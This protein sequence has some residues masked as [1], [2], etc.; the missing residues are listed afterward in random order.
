MPIL[1]KT[2][3][4]LPLDWEAHNNLGYTLQALGQSSVAE[5][6]CRRALE[7]KPDYP[8]AH[9]NLGNALKDLGRLEEAERS[10]RRALELKRDYAVVHSNLGNLLKDLG[11]LEEAERSYR[12]ALELKPDYAVAHSNLIFTLD[13][14]EHC[15]TRMQQEE[16][17]RWY[18]QH[19]RRYAQAIRPHENVPGPERKLR[20]G[21]VSADFCRRSPYYA[22]GSIICGHDHSAFEVVCYSEGLREDEATARLRR[23]AQVWRS[24]VGVS[25]EALAEQI[26][27]DRID[28]LVD[29]SAHM[30]GSRLLVFARKPAPVQVTAWGYANGTGLQTMDYFFADS[31]AVPSEERIHY[32]EEVTDLP[33]IICYEPPEYLPAVSPLPALSGKPFTF[34]CINR[35]EKITGSV[36]ALWCR[37]LAALPEARLVIKGWGLYDQGLRGNLL[38]RFKNAD[39]DA[40]RVRLLGHSPHAEHLK[41]YHE[42]DLV[43][44]SY[45]HG[46]GIS[47]L[48]ALWMGVPVV[49]LKGSTVTSRVS[50]SILTA[51]KLQDWIAGSDEEYGRIALEA[52]RDLPRLGGV[53]QGLR[54]R[55]GASVVG[56]V[57]RYTRAVEATYRTVWRRWCA[58]ETAAHFDVGADDEIPQNKTDRIG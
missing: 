44:D 48:E 20:I 24:S 11:R 5:A 6:C 2:V 37:I 21:Y 15:D 35:P 36:I 19:G 41:I 38:Q 57:P 7:L 13:L 4:L 53:R 46:G 45:P 55:A 40:E 43:L 12:R 26:R 50:A 42:V 16:R 56:D 32:A 58:D 34:G 27:R 51:L 23:A 28:I 54:A 9:N 29:L 18:L 17:R 25:D 47:T 14:M 22:F 8:E 31:V 49:T 30:A 33:C 39:I 3:A 1:Q 10:Y 52:A